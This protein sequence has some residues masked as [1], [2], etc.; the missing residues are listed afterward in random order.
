MVKKIC[1]Y[2]EARQRT[3][4]LQGVHW[5]PH[6]IYQRNFQGVQRVIFDAVGGSDRYNLDVV[7]YRNLAYN[8]VGKLVCSW[9]QSEREFSFSVNWNTANLFPL[10]ANELY[11]NIVVSR[12]RHVLYM[13]LEWG[14]MYGLKDRPLVSSSNRRSASLRF[15]HAE[16]PS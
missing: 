5:P 14:R 12:G 3:Y 15:Y 16:F 11:T 1:R 2:Q 9:P 4:L 13:R 8:T 6:V 10:L 7:L